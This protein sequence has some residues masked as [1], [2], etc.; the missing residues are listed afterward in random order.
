MAEA[1]IDV[2]SNT[3]IPAELLHDQGTVFVGKVTKTLC[4]LL[5]VKQIKTTAYHNVK[6]IK[7]TAYHP[8]ANG[9]LE[10]W[11]SC[12]KD[13]LRKQE[14]GPR[15][16][17][18]LLKYCLLAYRATPHSG[19]LFSPYEVVH[20]RQL[21]GPLQALKEG[22]T[23]GELKF[24]TSIDWVNQLR[25]TLAQLQKV[26]YDNDEKFKEG[27]KK[28]YDRG[29]VKRDYKPGG[30]VLLHTPSLSGNLSTVWEGPYEVMQVLSPT[31]YK[32]SVPGKRRHTLTTHV[33]RLKDWKI[34]QANIF[35]IVM[36][37]D[38]PD[39]DGPVGAVQ[40]SEPKLEPAQEAE[41]Q[42]LL[43]QFKHVVCEKLGNTSPVTHT[44][45]TGQEAPVQVHPYRIAPAR[46]EELRLEIFSLRDE[47]IINYSQ[48]PWSAPM[49]PVRKANGQIRLCIDFHGL[50]NITVLDPY[51]MPHVA[52]EEGV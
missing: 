49:V 48:S 4:E 41:M 22:W 40:L 7:T 42:A 5:N 3:G 45:D 26:A 2:F 25:D 52:V 10:R 47:G 28:V 12:L 44:I 34:P 21:R 17:D 38:S 20:G 19:T 36:A 16:W 1:L 9:I 6:Q 13:M 15:E 18:C 37:R 8:Q 31:T 50:N 32:L 33:N 23:G 39:S 30:M 29:T 46:K 43:K 27:T 24:E 14:E 11:H 51:Q 35:S